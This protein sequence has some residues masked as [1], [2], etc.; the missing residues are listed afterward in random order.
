[1]K[2]EHFFWNKFIDH[3]FTHILPNFKYVN[4]EY[5]NWHLHDLV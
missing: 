1:M 3:H 4:I 5:Y 2:L